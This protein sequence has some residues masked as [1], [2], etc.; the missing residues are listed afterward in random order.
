MPPERHSSPSARP[1][2]DRFPG[3]GGFGGAPRRS[4]GG[5]G[6]HGGGPP[7]DSGPRPPFTPRPPLPPP[8]PLHTVRLRDG[9]RE[10]EVSGTPE[11]VRQTLDD[12]PGLLARFR[13]EAVPHTRPASIAL[14]PV[15]READPEPAPAPAPAA[16]EHNEDDEDDEDAA[17]PPRAQRNGKS[18]GNGR[19]RHA[20]ASLEDRVFQLLGHT[21]HPLSVASIR[22][23]LGGAESGQQIRRILER[24][25]DRV[26]STDERPAAYAL[27]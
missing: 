24:A 1:P 13:G 4:F 26:Y 12:L 27:R 17:P 7:R 5:P 16:D 19:V 20:P 21:D 11:F 3:Q 6:G 25:S 23:Q 18:G 10:V 2:R 8:A 14:P 9:E 22:K 15:P